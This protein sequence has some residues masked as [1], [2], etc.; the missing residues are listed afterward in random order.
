MTS[1]RNAFIFFILGILIVA[2]HSRKSNSTATSTDSLNMKNDSSL[3]LFVGTYTNIDTPLE[4]KSTGIYIYRM[5]MHTGALTPYAASP[6]T[7]NPSYL[8]IHPNKEYVYAVNENGG[9][10]ASD[11]GGV[12]AFRLNPGS[13]QMRMLN[14]V[15]SMGKFP[16]HISVDASG[17][18]VMVANYGSG[19]FALYRIKEDGS[20]GNASS[21]VQHKG[22]GPHKNQDGP[23]AHMIMQD[24]EGHFVYTSDLGTDRIQ[25]Y[26]IDTAK[27]ELVQVQE[28]SV[29]PGTGP[30]H[31]VFH[32]S[33]PWFYV[34][35]EL[36]GTIEAFTR[37]K[38]TGALKRFQVISTLPAGLNRDASCAAIHISPSGKFLYAS[39]RG[40]VNTIA[41]FSVND[42]TGE[43]SP[44][45]QQDTK[46]RWP[47][48]FTL[49][50]TGSFL[51][52]ANQG[53][54]NVVIFRIDPTTGLL[55]ETGMEARIPSPV[56][57]KFY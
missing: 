4:A 24:P 54:N 7:S 29:L 32:P 56:C 41:I 53:T 52:V 46:G 22:K 20:L 1:L 34:V 2:C 39:N 40:D 12:S 16:C 27:N 48:S 42:H 49:D 15:S 44:V 14:S 50:P 57:L 36:N 28:T 38:E 5:N 23:H 18:F 11:M 47:R 21:V 31:F 26:R 35:G 33:Q 19:N 37:N 30:R 13:L 55:H 51:L 3:F 9:P 6:A 25:V 43:L 17:K 8:C 45:G 10:G